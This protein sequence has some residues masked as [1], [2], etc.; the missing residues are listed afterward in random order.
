[1]VVNTQFHKFYGRSF[2]R[3]VYLFLINDIGRWLPWMLPGST[4]RF[5]ITILCTDTWKI[6]KRQLWVRPIE[7]LKFNF[8]SCVRG[9]IDTFVGRA[10]SIPGISFII[11][12]LWTKLTIWLLILSFTNFTEGRSRVFYIS[13]SWRI[14][15]T[16]TWYKILTPEY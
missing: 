2:A 5:S 16:P 1:M 15:F 4:G 8:A 7:W 11:W 14:F 13:S 6:E 9:T 12:C 10:Y 3:V